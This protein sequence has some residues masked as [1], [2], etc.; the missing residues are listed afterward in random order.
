MLLCQ[1]GWG[2]GAS[3]PLVLQGGGLE[4][5]LIISLHEGAL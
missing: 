4:M 3:L 2:D 1:W 5:E